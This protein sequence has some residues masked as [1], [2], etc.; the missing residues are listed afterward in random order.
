[1]F[2]LSTGES[3]WEIDIKDLS[4]STVPD[5]TEF[6]LRIQEQR[7]L[8]FKDRHRTGNSVSSSGP[9]RIQH[10]EIL[11]GLLDRALYIAGS[12]R[13]YPFSLAMDL[14]LYPDHIQKWAGYWQSSD[15]CKN[16][17]RMDAHLRYEHLTSMMS[18]FLITEMDAVVRGLGFKAVGAS[19][20]KMNYA[21]AGQMDHYETLLKPA[22]ISMDTI[23]PIPLMLSIHMEPA[24]HNPIPPVN[25]SVYSVNGIFAV[26]KNNRTT[27][28]L[29]FNRRLDEYAISGETAGTDGTAVT[30]L[31]M[32]RDEYAPVAAGLLK[33]CLEITS[34]NEK[35][36]FSLRMNPDSYPDLYLEIVRLIYSRPHDPGP[37]LLRPG[38]DHMVFFRYRPEPDSGFILPVHRFLKQVGYEF[39]ELQF[40]I[41]PFQKADRIPG[42]ATHLESLGLKPGDPV[43]LPGIV[44]LIASGTE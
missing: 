36:E 30:F 23:I 20:E 15:L 28:Y 6:H 35:D 37:D 29:S 12:V 24:P 8:T 14:G 17:D 32:T 27:I 9:L 26:A 11:S 38:L 13:N 16:W 19:M 33:A 4:L 3:N 42:L 7:H 5:Q 22:G 31:P 43:F 41:E 25:E 10:V 21:R 40:S 39:K 1:M 2:T 44:Y 18:G 34:G